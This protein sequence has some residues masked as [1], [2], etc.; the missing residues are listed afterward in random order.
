MALNLKIQSLP[1]Y[2]LM[3]Y[4]GHFDGSCIEQLINEVLEACEKYKPVK[5]MA[6]FRT[7]TGTMTTME[8]FELGS[9]FAVRYMG[10]RMAGKILSCQFAFV[11]S[12]PLIDPRRF[13]ETVAK[14]R[15]INVMAFTDMDKGV[16]WL[17]NEE[18]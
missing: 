10:K 18:K 5:L 2:L 13:G 14:N 6:D 15:G 16:K 7:V 4:E 3:V 9:V 12:Y 17:E 8:R 1:H 11:G